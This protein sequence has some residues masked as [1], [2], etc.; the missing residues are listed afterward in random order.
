MRGAA[1]VAKRFT[2][3]RKKLQSPRNARTSDKEEGG[4][5]DL[6]AANLSDPGRIPWGVRRYPRYDTLSEPKKHLSKLSFNLKWRRRWNSFCKLALCS[7]WDLVWTIRSSMYTITLSSPR[8][9]SSIILWKE[10]GPP[11]SP[12]ANTLYW[13]WPIPGTVKAVNCLDLASR[14]SCQKPE[15]RSMVEKMVDSD[16]PISPM[17]SLMS[18]MEYLSSRLASLRP[19]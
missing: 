2:W 11:F 9:V 7:S 18:F 16:L 13:Y 5:A 10:P 19:L 4:G 3:D 1:S 12:M 15:V 17:H 14:G 6:I 8:H